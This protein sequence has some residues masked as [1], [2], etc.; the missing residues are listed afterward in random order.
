M[1]RSARMA[2]WL[3]FDPAVTGALAPNH[4]RALA[5]TSLAALPAVLAV[6]LSGGYG[7]WLASDAVV[8]SVVVGMGVSVY[9]ANL[10]RLSV[11]G[12]GAAAHEDASRALRWSPRVVP[13]VILALLGAFFA[14]PLLLG[15]LRPRHDERVDAL[16]QALVRMHEEAAVSHVRVALADAQAALQ[17]AEQRR[18]ELRARVARNQRELDALNRGPDVDGRDVERRV[19]LSAAEDHQAELTRLE[20]R[21]E[22]AQRKV[23]EWTGA[24]RNVL[25]K[26][27]AVYTAHL[28]R[29]HFLLRRVQL[30]WEDPVTSGLWTLG[31]ILL[32]ILPWLF[33]A[34]ISRGASR[35]YEALRRM[36]TRDV[37]ETAYRAARA[38]EERILRHWPTFSGL[39]LEAFDDPPYNTRPRVVARHG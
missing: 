24:E 32:L 17:D 34:T 7:T 27:V 29:S 3:G 21:V 35:A 2:A 14:Q 4:A 28:K 33:T 9:L 18:A 12:G 6:G 36:L 16:R 23:D 8:L 15:F 1:S 39:R 22:D 25:E 5:A 26:D 19:L 11:A 20:R 38:E 13:L 31:I 37:V 10:L 30:A